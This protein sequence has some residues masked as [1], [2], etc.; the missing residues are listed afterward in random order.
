MKNIKILLIFIFA[1]TTIYLFGKIWSVKNEPA[2]NIVQ[3]EIPVKKNDEIKIVENE[4]PKEEKELTYKIDAIVVWNGA[5]PYPLDWGNTVPELRVAVDAFEKKWGKPLYVRQVY[6]PIGYMHHMRSVWE[7]WRYTNGKSYKQGYMC[8]N[9]TH[10]DTTN[11]GVLNDKQKSYLNTEAKRHGFASGD[12]PPGC[13]SDHAKGIAV[14][15]TPPYEP[16][17]YERF[18]DTAYSVGLCHYIKGD[19]PHFGLTSQLP[20]GTDCFVK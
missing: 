14:D 8:E 18:L 10:I 4:K 3:A 15:I 1:L 7:V 16:K 17:E 9:F 5:E 19:E 6:R 2:S 20:E 13:V 12:T 11:I